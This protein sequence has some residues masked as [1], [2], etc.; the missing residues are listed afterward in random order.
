MS[1]YYTLLVGGV[2]SLHHPS[3]RLSTLR[4]FKELGA[5]VW[6]IMAYSGNLDP[7]FERLANEEVSI[8]KTAADLSVA[9]ELGNDLVVV[10]SESYENMIWVQ[11]YLARHPEAMEKVNSALAEGGKRE[12]KG[13]LN[14]RYYLDVFFEDFGLEAIESC[15]IDKK[16]LKVATHGC[17]MLKDKEGKGGHH[18][19][20]LMDKL[21]ETTGAKIVNYGCKYL[22]CGYPSTKV[23]H[24]YAYL[25]RLAPN[26][27]AMVRA[28]AEV[29]VLGSSMCLTHF[30]NGKAALEDYG[31]IYTL[32]CL[33]LTEL[34]AL[35]FGMRP[36]EMELKSGRLVTGSFAEKIWKEEVGF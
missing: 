29:A 26:L 11:N 30:I 28:G 18:R 22:D 14:V 6:E 31:R 10:G 8:L 21:V 12:Y 32:P 13:K 2:I 36:K 25:E 35:S 17:R 23:S 33:H 1:K 7:V 9:E 34:L 19:L 24:R 4:I 5:D 27:D 15:V 20:D 16:E 3:V